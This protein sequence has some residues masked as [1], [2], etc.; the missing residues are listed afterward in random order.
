MKIRRMTFL[1]AALMAPALELGPVACP[2]AAQQS[3]A[4]SLQPAASARPLD[5]DRGAAAL[6]QDLLKL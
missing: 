1:I 2:L 3:R 4:T 5:I 6:W